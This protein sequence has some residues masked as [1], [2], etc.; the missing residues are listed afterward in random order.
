MS[1]DIA[2]ALVDTA[3]ERIRDATDKA[4]ERAEDLAEFFDYDLD[5]SSV[6]RTRILQSVRVGFGKVWNSRRGKA[7][8]IGAVIYLAVTDWWRGGGNSNSNY[9]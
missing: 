1:G 8:T 3:E 7:A 9:Q 4:L 2:E 6:N 5:L